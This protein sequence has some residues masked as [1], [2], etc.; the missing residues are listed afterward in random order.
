MK[1]NVEQ[2]LRQELLELIGACYPFANLASEIVTNR[3]LIGTFDEE[4]LL[5]LRVAVIKAGKLL[6]RLNQ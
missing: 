2:E 3:K 5:N 6:E 4:D 1:V